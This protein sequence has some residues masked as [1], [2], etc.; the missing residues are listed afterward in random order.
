VVSP[1]PPP[2]PAPPPGLGP[3]HG[4]SAGAAAIADSPCATLPA[5]GT[6]CSPRSRRDGA[7]A[8]RT[9]PRLLREI[10]RRFFYD[11]QIKLGTGQLPA[12]PR[13]LGFQ[14]RHRSLHWHRR[15]RDRCPF[16][17]S[18]HPVRHGRLRNPQPFGCR[19]AARR[20][21]HPD[22]LSLELLGVPPIRNRFLLSHL[23]LRSSKRY[24]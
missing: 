2:P 24:Q 17:T 7:R 16:S 5:A 18:S 6:S 13:V 21:R 1:L 22:R 20:Q 9:A 14:L 15:A 19:I 8:S 4:R 23:A 10:R 3:A 11:L 12:Q